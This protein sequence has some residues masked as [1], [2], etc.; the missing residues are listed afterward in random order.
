MTRNPIIPENTNK[1][2]FI[3]WQQLNLTIIDLSVWIIFIGLGA[4]LGFFLW[5]LG[6]VWKPIAILSASLCLIAGF[7]LN[8][9]SQFHNKKFYA[10]IFDWFIFLFVNKKYKLKIKNSTLNLIPYK[11]IEGEYILLKNKLYMSLIKIQGNSF[12]DYEQ[13]KQNNIL[14]KI[15]E[16]YNSLKMGGSIIKLDELKSRNQ[17]LF[18]LEE[19]RHEWEVKRKNGEINDKQYFSRV[20]LIE[21]DIEKYSNLEA[22]SVL[23]W[24]EKSIYIVFYAESIDQLKQIENKIINEYRR[25]DLNAHKIDIS[26][27]VNVLNKIVDI[28]ILDDNENNIFKY[29]DTLDEYFGYDTLENKASYLK[30]DNNLKISIGSVDNYPGEPDCGWLGQIFNIDSPVIINFN[31]VSDKVFQET[32]SK[33]RRTAIATANATSKK[34]I[35]TQRKR[36]QEIEKLE[37]FADTIGYGHDQLYKFNI[38]IIN[39]GINNK[40]L[41]KS[42]KETKKIL[43]QQ[44]LTLF[45][46]PYKQIE[47]FSGMLPKPHDPLMEINGREVP[48]YSLVWGMPYIN[49]SLNDLQGWF[50]GNSIVGDELF[51]NPHIRNEERRNAN[52]FFVATTGAGKS[53]TMQ[54][55]LKNE[56]LNGNRVYVI[57]PENEYSRFADYFGEDKIFLGDGIYKI[58]PLQIMPT[59][60]DLQNEE[61]KEK[62]EYNKK[63]WNIDKEKTISKEF[64]LNE[65][66]I[67][68]HQ[69]I[70]E[71]LFKNFFNDISEEDTRYLKNKFWFFYNYWLNNASNKNILE[72]KNNEFP[73]LQDFYNWLIKN[74]ENNSLYNKLIELLE[75]GFVISQNGLKKG[76]YSMFYNGYTSIDISNRYLTIFDMSSLKDGSDKRLLSMQMFLV[77]KLLERQVKVNHGKQPNVAQRI[78]VDE[79]HL[80]M[81]KDFPIALDFIFRMVK[82]IRKR[83]G[84]ITIITQNAED[85]LSNEEIEKK[86]K[87]IINNSQ[88][89]F[90]MKS[91][92]KNIDK[93]ESLYSDS[94]GFTYQEKSHLID[95]PNGEGLLITSR[96]KRFLLKIDVQPDDFKIISGDETDLVKWTLNYLTTRLFNII[97]G[98]KFINI[99]Q[100]NCVDINREKEEKTLIIKLKDNHKIN[101][102]L[103]KNNIEIDN[104]RIINN[105]LE[106]NF[107]ELHKEIAIKFYDKVRKKIDLIRGGKE[108]DI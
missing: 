40:E 56:I 29:K 73:I 49:N 61:E 81:D 101:E 69:S 100:E 76:S 15:W 16:I 82:M 66:L 9:K 3:I 95:A 98:L 108:S 13:I 6:G 47:A 93:I 79:A 87:A 28:D 59:L 107:K 48:L 10:V 99:D 80:L 26:K 14:E 63:F 27:K 51:F 58:N 92:A 42:I 36:Q 35:L 84:G 72:W 70:V 44:K 91:T 85:F 65:A 67:L 90:I 54:R 60:S 12:F 52:M 62:I 77:I 34:E 71:I 55:M 32:L 75:D 97:N 94:D 5:K 41:N 1:R 37:E 50:I 39:K 23:E 45:A 102:S 74:K 24:I 21:K 68:N 33:A 64:N 83:N 38:Y 2:K 57:D 78:I 7:L 88:Y 43:K 103:L 104:V 46:N 22:N 106:I 20:R 86:T 8:T 53:T 105:S 18:F 19:K 96:T 4:I 31:K 30:I 89:A 17:S 25:A 11:S